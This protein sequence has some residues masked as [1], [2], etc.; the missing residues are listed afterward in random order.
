[1]STENKAGLNALPTPEEGVL[2]LI[3]DMVQAG[4][5]PIAWPAVMGEWQ[6]DRARE[7]TVP[8]AAEL[9]QDHGGATGVAFAWEMRLLAERA[10]GSGA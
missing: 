6:R 8:G 9:Q 3:D 2:V 10:A 5:V 4:V 7:K 1:M